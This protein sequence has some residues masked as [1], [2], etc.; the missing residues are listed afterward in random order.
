MLL[1][2]SGC[3]TMTHSAGAQSTLATG[4][5]G[6]EISTAEIAADLGAI[7]QREDTDQHVVMMT[8][9]ASMGYD[10]QKRGVWINPIS[11]EIERLFG[12][13][14]RLWAV[15]V[16]VSPSIIEVSDDPPRMGYPD[17]STKVNLAAGISL[18]LIQSYTPV[19]KVGK[20]HALHVRLVPQVLVR[21]LEGNPSAYPSISL[22]ISRR[23]IIRA[24]RRPK[25]YHDE[26]PSRPHYAPSDGAPAPR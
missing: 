22:S 16:A 15:G 10:V 20:T 6:L 18:G 23:V 13:N 24:R 5:E 8:M 1:G 26:E 12:Q 21:D 3:T 25:R 19:Q 4:P 14:D 7:V 11:Y 9:N 2:V 17:R